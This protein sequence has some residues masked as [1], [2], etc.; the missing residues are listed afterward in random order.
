M[1]QQIKDVMTG[2]PRVLEAKES[3]AA[4]ARCMATDGIGDVIVVKDGEICG[5]VT[6]R[7]ITIR[8][9]AEGRDPATTMLADVCSSDLTTVLP[10]DSIGDAVGLMHE[11]AV[12]RL[13]VVEGGKPVGIVSIGDLA[14]EQ[15][16]DSALAQISAAPANR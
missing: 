1:A 10:G 16:R 2:S 5:I 9:I 11:R 6:D 8:V 15:D 14:L 4:A 7:D 13:P 12:R 3:V